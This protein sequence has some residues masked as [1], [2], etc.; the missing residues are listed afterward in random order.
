MWYNHT[1]LQLCIGQQIVS[2]LKL[3]YRSQ[4]FNDDAANFSAAYYATAS[5][6][7]DNTGFEF[8]SIK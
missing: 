4:G 5:E 3:L 1:K 6:V 2:N 8:E 7:V